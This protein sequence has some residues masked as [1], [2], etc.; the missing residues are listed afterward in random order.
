[1]VFETN[2]NS[3]ARSL[4]ISKTQPMQDFFFLKTNGN[5]IRVDYSDIIYIECLKN[6]VRIGTTKKAYI[7]LITMKHVEEI[8]PQELFC[9]IHR[10]YIVSLKQ[11]SR[12]DQKYVY[13]GEKKLP[14]SEQYRNTLI[15]K[16]IILT[17]E[18][19]SKVGFSKN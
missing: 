6:Y 5:Y 16:F 1:L 13:V 8:L 9:R 12:F 15:G 10:S 7:I 18:S 19:R 11:I 3:F 2:Q 14:V 4:K 17:P